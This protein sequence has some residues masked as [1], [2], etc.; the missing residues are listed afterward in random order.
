MV[1]VVF[2]P[3]LTLMSLI[4]HQPVVSLCDCVLFRPREVD[5]YMVHVSVALRVCVRSSARSA[6]F[7]GALGLPN[8]LTAA[9]T[10]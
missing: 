7:S 1:V 10:M 4:L 3:S 5:F 2:G 6:L 9:I 8:P